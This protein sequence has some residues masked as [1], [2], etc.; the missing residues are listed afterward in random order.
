M[1]KQRIGFWVYD[2]LL[3]LGGLLGLPLWLALLLLIP[4]WRAGAWEKL[5]FYTIETRH[6]FAAIN[7]RKGVVWFHAVSVGEFLAIKPVLEQLL[8]EDK[9]SLVLSYTTKTGC[10]L[11][12][13]TFADAIASGRLVTLFLPLDARWMIDQAFRLIRP[14]RLVLVETELWLNLIYR[15]KHRHHC[16]VWIVNGRLSKRSFPRYYLLRHTVMQPLLRCVDALFAQSP[17]DAD[18]FI[19][20]GADPERVRALGNLKFDATPK[21]REAAL[22]KTLKPLLNFKPQHKVLTIASTHVGEDEQLI[23]LLPT[24]LKDIPELRVVIA[25]RHPERFAAVKKLLSSEVLPFSIRS[26]LTPEAP[27][28][29]PIVLLNTIGELAAVYQLSHVALL[30]GSFVPV[31]GHNILEP[32]MA[33]VPVLFGPFM[34]NFELIQTLVLEAHAGV[35]LEEPQALRNCLMQLYSQP[36]RHQAMQKEGAALIQLFQGNKQRFIDALYASF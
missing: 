1:M 9:L 23:P 10:E 36:E 17:Q 13:A 15:A 5:G 8:A 16:Q 35:R 6:R 4:K 34:H 24:L 2:A 32:L 33:G 19:A 29:Q 30:G 7:R 26:Q 31:G 20:L 11:A 3:L 12:N 28:E 27:N 18:R 22:L 25:P 21:E 14:D